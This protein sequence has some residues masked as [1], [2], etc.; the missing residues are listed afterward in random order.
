V[1]A[2]ETGRESRGLP[3]P[4]VTDAKT[5]AVPVK[6]SASTRG[7]PKPESP[8]ESVLP[9]EAEAGE[10]AVSPEDRHGRAEIAKVRM[11]CLIKLIVR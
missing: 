10:A 5:P 3:D 11:R 8:V 1:V 6:R 9:T 4:S 2:A 7:N